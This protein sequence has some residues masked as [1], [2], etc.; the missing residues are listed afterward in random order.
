M[1][2]CIYLMC[3]VLCVVVSLV[4]GETAHKCTQLFM[5]TINVYGLYMFILF[6]PKLN[7]DV[8]LTK[9]VFQM[10]GVNVLTLLQM[11][12]KLKL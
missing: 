1:D 11:E 8:K 3:C 7:Q 2:V 6:N 12:A 9:L 10:C 4:L 5:Q